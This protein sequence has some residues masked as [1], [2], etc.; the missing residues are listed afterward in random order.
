MNKNTPFILNP[1]AKACL[2]TLGLG[3]TTTTFA[4]E[5]KTSKEQ[6][7]EVIE[8]S[9]MRS[10]LAHALQ[11]KRNAASIV[12]GI[13]AEDIGKFPDQNVAESLQRISGVAISRENGEGSKLT[14]RGF[15]PEFNVVQVNGRTIATTGKGRSLDF[16]LLPSELISGADVTKT[17][18][19]KT[20]EG[21]IGGYVNVKT[22]HPL[23]N[24]GFKA[25]A[26]TQFKYND[27]SEDYGPKF[28][29]IVS[30][31]FLDDSFGVLVG[32]TH[33]ESTNRID[34]AETNRWSTVKAS[35]IEGDIRDQKGN[36]VTPTELWYPG[37]YRFNLIEE[38][39]ERTGA[40]L[41][42]EFAQTDD[43]THRVDYLYSDFTREEVRQGMQIPMQYS[44][45]R[46]VVV[47]DHG[48]VISGTK[49]GRQP[50][51]GQFG[52]SGSQTKTKAI[53]YN[54]LAFV[55]DFTFNFDASHSSANATPR[56]DNLVPNYINGTASTDELVTFD[57]TGGGIIDYE[58]TVDFANPANAKAH[59]NSVTHEQLSDEIT[60]LKFDVNY[61]IGTGILDSIDAGF[62]YSDREKTVDTYRTKNGCRNLDLTP[63]DSICGK[64]IDLPDELFAVNSTDNFL[65]EE[66]GT[67][68]RQF[69]LVTSIS[70][71]HSEIARLR[72]EPTWPNEVY[73]ETRS[74]GTEETRKSVF[75]QLNISGELG[76]YNWSGNL[77]LR[78]VET[79]T[80]S[81][82]YGKNR[83]AIT[84]NIN[85]SG[86]PSVEV[87]YSVPGQITRKNSY[88]N[89]LP[90]A[91]FKLDI[92]DNIVARFSGAKVMSLPSITD[93]GV[94]RIYS[95]NHAG[96][97]SS[98]G[99]NPLLN[100]YEA[101]QFDLSL[102]YYQ[103]NGNAYAIN[104]FT[105]NIETF[106]S[107]QTTRDETPDIY[108][109]GQYQDSTVTIPDYGNLFETITQMDNRDGGKIK[110]IEISALH[111]FD[112][113][114]GFLNGFGL[115]ANFTY[116][117]SKDKSA[118][119]IDIEGVTDA[120]VGLEGFSDTS[121]NIIAFYE[122]D[123]WQGRIAYNWRDDYLLSRS[124]T[125]SGGLPEHVEAYGQLDASFS[126]DFTEK[127]TV[128]LE[129]VNL[130]NERVYE[131]VDVIER[132]SRVQ[133]TG[134][135]Y[136]LSIRATF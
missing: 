135:R 98:R 44:G 81:S 62:S 16:Q 29:G 117:D 58:T 63:A 53:G 51:D 121:Y 107:T 89:L 3:I 82:G 30:N 27:L 74:T 122:K 1:V 72:Q 88:D 103:E 79:E 21:S 118:M 132:L 19:G 87:T 4:E 100:P 5:T 119:P 28:S 95:D 22:A 47:S 26:S 55:D 7:V 6:A 105:K 73:D 24:P 76:D 71:Y 96:N 68:P 115:Q 2:F 52:V 110:G 102:E 97:F 20:P 129:A 90:S 48:S 83:L 113:L 35:N 67:F 94:N 127:L 10:S 33:Q 14:V 36:V 17:P 93:I 116:L 15:G 131:Y 69:M 37:R 130:T 133:Y 111:Y 108:V 9:G 8:V 23:S 34:S 84:P 46:D 126:Y 60:E 123:A 13:A 31:T 41:T 92:N 91:N 134:T 38:Q 112:Y 25:A 43:I 106:I 65:S 49:F 124:G 78:Y 59:W 128:S 12:D 109:D 18:M 45:W 61:A 104:F 114:P 80:T 11:D 85:A 40:N 101:T 54:L 75:T 32:F 42:L 77:G 50:L 39:R 64:F 120:G 56:Q 70:D 66:S 125:R 136:T 99:G 86:E 57:M